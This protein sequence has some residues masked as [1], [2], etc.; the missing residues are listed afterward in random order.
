[1]LRRV[2][3]QQAQIG[4]QMT[5][6]YGSGR[7]RWKRNW[8]LILSKVSQLFHP[9]KPLLSLESLLIVSS[10]RV[11]ID[12]RVSVAAIDAVDSAHFDQILERQMRVD[13]SQL[14]RRRSR[15]NL[16]RRKKRRRVGRCCTTSMCLA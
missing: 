16:R 14:D 9:L 11:L 3:E 7:E 13:G 10:S 4:Q 8:R 12:L 2:H 15:C 6:A 1:M 5:V